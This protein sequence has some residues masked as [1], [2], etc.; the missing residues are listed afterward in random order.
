MRSRVDDVMGYVVGESRPYSVSIVSS[1]PLMLGE[2]VEIRYGGITVIGLIQASMSGSYII[3]ETL[4]PEDLR[5]IINIHKGD[6]GAIYYKGHVKILG[7]PEEL[8]IPPI[9]PPP[10]IEVRRA[11]HKTLSKIFAPEGPQWARVGTLL[12]NPEVEVRVDLNKIVQRHLAILAMTGMGKSNLVSLLAR[13]ILRRGGTTF[14]FDYH[15]EYVGLEFEGMPSPNVIKARINPRYLSWQE[16]ARLI[17]VRHGAK[18]QENV[19]KKCKEDLDYAE[20]NGQR[21]YLEAMINCIKREKQLARRGETMR[22]CE[23]V[24]ETIEANRH[25]LLKI[26]DDDARDITDQSA[27]G[28]INIIDLTGLS[29]YL[30][31]DAVVSHWLGRI[32]EERKASTWR[33]NSDQ[34]PRLPHPVVVV[35]EEAHIYLS[36][37]RDT[38]TKPRAEHIAREGRKFG[39]GLIVVSQR[40]RGLDPDVLSQMGSMAIMRIVQPEDQAHIARASENLTQEILEQLPGLNIGEAILLGHWVRMPAVVK[41]DHVVEKTAGVDIDAVREWISWKQGE[42]SK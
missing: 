3:D 25:L 26:V 19:I 2:Y 23:A 30:Q 8:R 37:E 28:R 7:D 10:G 36:T 35:L 31:A 21:S 41:I 32:L 27:I 24:I 34:Q 14:I 22:A 16:F 42:K 20:V 11:S 18:N 13:E 12:R 6:E 39:V 40:P 1:K 38:L 33:R 5:K 17:G 15:G 4:P 29:S 9:P